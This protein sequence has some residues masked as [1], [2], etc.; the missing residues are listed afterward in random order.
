MGT[1]RAWALVALGVCAAVGTAA[2]G[3][4][5]PISAAEAA[6]VV[7]PSATPDVDPLAAAKVPAAKVD[8]GRPR[9]LADLVRRRPDVFVGTGVE[10]HGVTIVALNPGV[11]VRSWRPVIARYA[12]TQPYLVTSCPYSLAELTRVSGELTG[13]DWSPRA[14]RISFAVVIDPV[15]CSV[16]LASAD[17]TDAERAALTSRYGDAITIVKAA[18]ER[19]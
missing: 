16:Q 7:E 2:C 15:T 13:R 19:A 10:N 9:D 11:D 4:R 8:L 5:A 12:G 6:V 3:T 17:L 14:K 1:A 18:A